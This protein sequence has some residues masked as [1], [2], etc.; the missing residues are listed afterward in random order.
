MTHMGRIPSLPPRGGRGYVAIP[1]V[2]LAIG[3]G[4][5][6]PPTAPAAAPPADVTAALTGGWLWL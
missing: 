4:S 6:D 2:V 5:T 3:C 1:L